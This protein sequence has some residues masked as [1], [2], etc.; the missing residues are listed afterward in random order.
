MYTY[1]F[2][3]KDKPETVD[4]AVTQLWA[5]S[6]I[7]KDVYTGN[8]DILNRLSGADTFVYAT[9]AGAYY[10]DCGD[11][12]SFKIDNKP[13]ADADYIYDKDDSV[14]YKITGSNIKS[15]LVADRKTGEFNSIDSMTRDNRIICC[16]LLRMEQ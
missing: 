5:Q 8:A 14:I 4:D 15:A 7:V 3:K 12:T 9:A 10:Y 6:D 11:N 16:L 13:D 2:E 1:N